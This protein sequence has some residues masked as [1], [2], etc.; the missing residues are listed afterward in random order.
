[1]KNAREALVT[2]IIRI[3]ERTHHRMHFQMKVPFFSSTSSSFF[4]P[5]MMS[6]GSAAE[7]PTMMPSVSGECSGMKLPLIS[8][9]TMVPM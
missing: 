3:P 2:T 4:L 6:A 5:T 9:Q 1:M 7:S 8:A